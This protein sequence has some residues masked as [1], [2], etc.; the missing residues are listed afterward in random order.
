MRARAH[1]GLSALAPDVEL[2][3]DKVAADRRLPARPAE[4]QAAPGH[5]PAAARQRRRLPV[6]GHRA[7]AASRTLGAVVPGAAG[8]AERP[9]ARRPGAEDGPGGRGE[10][11]AKPDCAAPAL[12]CR[13]A[14]PRA[15]PAGGHR[16]EGAV[17]ASSSRLGGALLIGGGV[18]AIVSSCCSCSCS[19]ATTTRAAHRLRRGHGHAGGAPRR[20]PSARSASRAP[21]APR[22]RRDA[23][24]HRPAA[25]S[26]SRSRAPASPPNRSPTR[27][28]PSGS[29]SP[30]APRS[31]S[32]S[33]SPSAPTASSAPPAR[34]PRTSTVPALAGDVQAGRVSRESNGKRQDSPAPLVLLGTLPSG[35]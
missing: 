28:T 18:L 14:P 26:R 9:K 8:G 29:P 31:G 20:R 6:G 23:P 7:R 30:A 4:R 21:T 16:A 35:S 33:P 11:P 1:A 32:A 10:G 13:D 5:P 22:D 12:R 3:A 2:P 17:A 34:A 19:A 27:P 24:L 25:S 15:R